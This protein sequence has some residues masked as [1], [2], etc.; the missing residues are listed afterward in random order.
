M[1]TVI[2][3]SLIASVLAAGN[4][5]SVDDWEVC[6]YTTDCKSGT[7]K[8]CQA[9]LMKKGGGISTSSVCS[10]GTKDVA[11]SSSS[12]AGAKINC[13]AGKNGF[14]SNES[15]VGAAY[16]MAGVMAVFAAAGMSA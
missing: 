10:N 14:A 16:L 2:F 11:P 8:C 13:D 3:A 1:K 12:M 7:F 5:G 4:P 6:N 9:T 15:A